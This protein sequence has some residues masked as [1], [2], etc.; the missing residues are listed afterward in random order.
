VK[1]GYPGFWMNSDDP[2]QPKGLGDDWGD[3]H[4]G[5]AGDEINGDLLGLIDIAQEFNH[6]FI[7]HP[8]EEGHPSNIPAGTEETEPEPVVAGFC[9]DLDLPGFT[10]FNPG[11]PNNPGF[12]QFTFH[13]FNTDDPL[14]GDPV[15]DNATGLL[16]RWTQ[17]MMDEFGVDGFR[18]DAAKHVPSWFW[19]TFWD[20]V[21]YLRRETPAG[22]KVTPFSFVESVDSN[23]YTYENYTRK[24]DGF[25]NRDALDISGSGELRNLVNAGGFGSWQSVLSA[26]IDTADDGFNNG[27]L[28]VNHVFSHD[29]GSVGDGGSLPPLPTKKQQGYAANA[30]A[31]LRPGP[32][33]V[34][35]NA[36][37]IDRDF[38]FFPREGI[39]LALGLDPATG[40]PDDTITGLV[41]IRT[42]AGRGDID[43]LNFT[44]PVDQSL[45]DVLVFERKGADG[46]NLLVGVNDRYDPGAE[47]RDVKTS[48]PPGTRLHEMTG[49][50]AD[51]QVDP[52]DDVPEILVVGADQRVLI[53]VPNNRSGAGEHHK[54]YVAYIPTLP[55][56][57]LEIS[58][59]A[60]E[61]PPDPPQAPD[62]LQRLTPVPIVDA[63]AF[64]ITLTTTQTDPLDPN[65]DDDAAFRIDQGFVD[66]NAD[67]DVDFPQFGTPT[68]G[69]ERFLTVN[70]PLFGGDDDE[71]L[72]QQEIDATTLDEGYHYLS[73][74]AF[75]H[76]PA[77][78]G[79]LFNEWRRVIYLDR[80]GPAIEW[81]EEP[82]EDEQHL[83][84][85]R[86]LDRTTTRVH[87]FWDLPD[88]ADPVDL[89]DPLNMGFEH[90]RFEW[91]KTLLG[92]THGDHTLTLVAF[93]ESGNATVLDV[94]VF[95]NLCVA[96][97]D[98]DGELTIL[99][100]V[101]FQGAF[102][103]G[104]DRADVNG[105]GSLDIL[106][107]VTFQGLFQAG[108]E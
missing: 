23:Q 8:V 7:R 37:G 28:G 19:D 73:V 83:F 50:A 54:G 103:A 72:Y 102:L 84:K 26:H 55:S 18:L 68:P 44:D 33:I 22:S 49:N 91:R 101:A 17:W 34:Y 56:G 53:T 87:F 67:G 1:G 15:E 98:A 105:D 93:E 35:H 58:N 40:Q 27:S 11:T 104:D 29:N 5:T 66:H 52:G 92:L 25:G 86:L 42:L 94:P 46:T 96:D 10:F 106:D 9:A 77:G 69:Y 62:H 59:V 41:R 88:G 64:T 57:T 108:C 95:V 76:R 82:V 21:V 85:V 89:A 78:E 45:E 31:I 80:T 79:I 61:I 3:F 51:P 16:M 38:G 12:V 90:D 2:V 71:G 70:D 60:G 43:V 6:Q 107:F 99:D 24:G 47:T 36:R 74:V 48:F 32:P 63:D 100:F 4:D 30:Y 14:A 75:R 65:T 97:F 39:P 20:A 13:P 81:I